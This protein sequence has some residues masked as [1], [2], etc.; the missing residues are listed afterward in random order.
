MVRRVVTGKSYHLCAADPIDF[1]KDHVTVIDVVH[2]NQYGPRLIYIVA[3]DRSLCSRRL[4]N[5]CST[6]L[7]SSRI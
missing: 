3:T 2:E 7:D 1:I 5:I 4:R 6:L